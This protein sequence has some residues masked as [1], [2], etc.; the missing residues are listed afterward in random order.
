MPQLGEIKR[1]RIYWGKQRKYYHVRRLWAQCPICKENR[2]LRFS[3][4]DKEK[5]EGFDSQI[6]RR[7]WYMSRLGKQ[8]KHPNWKGGRW[9]NQGYVFTKIEITDP[10]I[11]MATQRG[12]GFTYYIP[13]HRLIFARYLG[14][15]LQRREVVHHLNGIRDD[16][17]IEN[18]AI[19]TKNTHPTDT[20]SK[21]FQKRIRELEREIQ[22]RVEL[23]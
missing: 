19:L 21:I 1:E 11:T 17:R 8:A 10:M 9:Y 5:R 6:C 15:C 22:T 4:Y 13:E 16:N 23:A 7:C 2:W 18:L 20:L 14:R 3:N 12:N